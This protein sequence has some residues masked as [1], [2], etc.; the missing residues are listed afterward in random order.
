MTQPTAKR[1]AIFGMGGFARL[2]HGSLQTL[3]NEGA[4][5]LVATCDLWPE[6][7]PELTA[8]LEARGVRIYRDYGELLAN[9]A[10]ELDYATV[11]T[12]IPLHA[13]MHR[14]CAERG[15]AVYLEKPPTLDWRELEAMIESDKAAP[16]AAAV[17]FNF[18]GETAR[19]ALK[20]RLV[21]GEFGALKRAGFLGCWPRSDAYFARASWSGRLRVGE[22]LVLDSCVGNA[23]AH[24]VHNLLFW[25]GTREVT[26]WGEV[27]SVEAELYRAHAIESFDTVFARG[28][29]GGI[30]IRVGAT[31]AAAGAEWQ[32]EWLEC[33]HARLIYKTRGGGWEIVWNDGRRESGPTDMDTTG[34]FLTR[35]L[36]QFI[37]TLSGENARPLTTLEDCRPFV[38]FNDLLFVAAKRITTLG[39][40]F[41]NE[42][43]NH[44]GETLRAIENIEDALEA[45][46]R[47]GQLPFERGLEWGESGGCAQASEI[48]Q[49]AG[50][51]DGLLSET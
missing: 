33:E 18:I 12:P 48:G 43:M 26:S 46:G 20:T 36:R 37:G 19:H 16:F 45:F 38:H 21:A 47:D 28:A 22:H 40:P 13:P 11:A 44:R 5:R 14:A 27:E 31:H 42:Q 9:H 49:L 8:N 50:V 34:D 6:N 30:E 4:A 23:L 2:H 7:F 29:C 1:A 17:G 25:C 3:E 15:V 51:I 10:H 35:N 32:R 39:V 24:Y 41:V